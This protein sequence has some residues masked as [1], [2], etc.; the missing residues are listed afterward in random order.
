MN[1]K[2]NGRPV[3]AISAKS[4]QITRSDTLSG[5]LILPANQNA[6]EITVPA[7]L[8]KKI[9]RAGMLYLKAAK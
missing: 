4:R 8:A 3:F 6:P 7:P 5:V 1:G 2:R 9:K